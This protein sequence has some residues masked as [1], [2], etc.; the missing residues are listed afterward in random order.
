MWITFYYIHKLQAH[1]ICIQFL[2]KF[3]NF[4]KA[5]DVEIL[6]S[7]KKN[8]FWGILNSTLGT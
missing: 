6:L 7:A 8:K 2:V 5:K 1:K 3:F 4:V